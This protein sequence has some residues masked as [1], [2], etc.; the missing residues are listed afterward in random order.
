VGE[1]A[2]NVSKQTHS[3]GRARGRA[4]S[5]TRAKLEIFLSPRAISYEYK[6]SDV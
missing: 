3:Q 1:A 6:F 5:Q 2:D 4:H